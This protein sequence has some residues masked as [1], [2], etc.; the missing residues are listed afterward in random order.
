MYELSVKNM[1]IHS[2]LQTCTNKIN[3]MKKL[4]RKEIFTRIYK[5][6]NDICEKVDPNKLHNFHQ[7][8][9][10]FRQWLIKVVQRNVPE[11]LFS[12]TIQVIG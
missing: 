2:A 3:K 12:F 9:V 8:Q 10:S 4:N 6:Q 5:I 11:C 7:K 1:R